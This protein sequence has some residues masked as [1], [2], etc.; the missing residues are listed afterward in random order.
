MFSNNN[1]NND[2]NNENEEQFNNSNTNLLDIFLYSSLG[3]YNNNETNSYFNNNFFNSGN[4]STITI[5]DST[6]SLNNNPINSINNSTTSFYRFNTS[7]ISIRR[8]RISTA[9]NFLLQETFNTLFD[10][11]LSYVDDIIYDDVINR[12]FDENRDK[13]LERKEDV[14]INFS[15][16]KYNSLKSEV[17]NGQINC[18]ICL[19][20]FEPENLISIT[21]C[22]HIFHKDCI[23]EWTHY[24]TNCP[25]CRD[26]LKK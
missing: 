12:S 16:E 9:T 6:T 23:K 20:D 22:N 24:K 21:S 1:N 15:Y 11:S 8:N 14:Y 19:N 2:N 7:P 3:I 26:E 25:V 10:T 18:A 5:N 13:E 17:I 4:H